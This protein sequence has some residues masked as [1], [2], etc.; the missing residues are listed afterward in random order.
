M[1][2]RG[3]RR[4]A[5]AA[6]KVSAAVAALLSV[7]VIG[8]PAAGGGALDGAVRAPLA[9]AG[10]VAPRPAAYALPVPGAVLVAFRA[11]DGPYGA[12]HRGVDLAAAAGATVHA[13]GAG[14]VAFAGSVAGRGVVVI[15]HPDGLSTEYEPLVATVRAGMGI[16]AGA[17][18]GRL[19]GS[20]AACQPASCLHWGARR[21]SD[22]LDPLSLLEP[23]G[24]V[25]L[26]PWSGTP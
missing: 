16:P 13:A 18:L 22:Y 10:A 23:L 6:L 24:V 5:V 20:H 3:V 14:V 25:R 4:A 1:G 11:P 9:G 17:V 8:A 26:L 15:R 7:G 12:G 2:C 19:S 21:G